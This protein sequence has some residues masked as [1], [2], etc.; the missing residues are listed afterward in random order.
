[1]KPS[2]VWFRQDLRLA[3]N[4]ALLA[5]IQRGGPV[6]PIYVW[7]PEDEGEWPAGAASRWWLHYAL[8]AL[9]TD[10]R[11]L[12]SRLIIRTGPVTETLTSLARETGAAAVFWNHRYEPAAIQVEKEVQIALAR[13]S[14]SMGAF[15][16]SLLFNPRETMNCQGSPFQVF[17]PYWKHC[18]SRPEPEPP[19]PAPS[20]LSRPSKWPAP[21]KPAD[22]NLL[23]KM[24]WADGIAQTWRPGEQAAGDVL[25]GFVRQALG[26]Y[27]EGRDRPEIAGTS[28]LSPYLHW[29]HISPRQIWH[30]VNKAIRRKPIRFAKQAAAY[31]RQLG[32]REFAH[33]LLVHFPHTPEEPLR[34]AFTRFPWIGRREDL[35]AWQRGRTGYPLVD[36]GMR[37][38]WHNGWM[39]N[40]VRMVVA[41]FL[42]KHLLV[43][44]QEGAR[45]FWDTLV[46]AD[47][48][49]NTLGWQ[50]CAGC[51]ADAAPYFRIFN[52]V[53]QGE[54]FDPQGTYVR[55]WV[56]ELAGLPD[57]LIHQPWKAKP[58][59]L[60]AAGV[61]LGR[62]YST[63]I[64]DHAEARRRAL[65]AY[66]RIKGK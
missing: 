8:T 45:W 63:P 60:A 22:L 31:L 7:S 46:D 11:Q 59:Q 36:A 19:K 56:P 15:H 37:E 34:E 4:P 26:D 40:R 12:G 49:N 35:Q 18:L 48:A 1:M 50:W 66:Q 10:L 44:W 3:D 54:K 6:I 2:L 52:P 13:L 30:A 51:G 65:D 25:A 24:K 16:G 5:A 55:R 43:P 9:D 47:L 32:W 29:G 28:R 17:T 42:V 38:L 14:I 41:S 61:E 64:V 62:T 21:L 39:H 23:P 27:S 57:S 58:A 53:L 33:H 20:R